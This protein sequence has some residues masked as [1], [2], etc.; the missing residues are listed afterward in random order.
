MNETVNDAVNTAT[1]YAT[2]ATQGDFPMWILLIVLGAL[3]YVAWIKGWLG[4]ETE[5][6]IKAKRADLYAKAHELLDKA[7]TEEKKLAA[8][9]AP[10]P[11]ATLEAVAAAPFD[12]GAQIVSL[13]DAL[14]KG[15]IKQDQYDAEVA[16][17]LAQ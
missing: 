5:D 13:H 7:K 16:K 8:I 4:K 3:A 14:L 11:S 12:K 2:E 6:K 15:A 1:K 10:I 17:I 9:Q